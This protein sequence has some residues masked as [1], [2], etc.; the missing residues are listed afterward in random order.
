MKYLSV[1]LIVITLI[2]LIFFM[3]FLHPVF[4]RS[5]RHKGRTTTR[6]KTTTEIPKPSDDTKTEPFNIITVPDKKCPTG[7]QADQKGVCRTVIKF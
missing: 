6:T 1:R 3:N 2:S 5:I 7:Q 4:S